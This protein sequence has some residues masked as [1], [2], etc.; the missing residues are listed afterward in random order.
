MDHFGGPKEG[1]TINS[2][3]ARRFNERNRPR[4]P[5]SQ[6]YGEAKWRSIKF[7]LCA[8]VE[9]KQVVFFFPLMYNNIHIYILVVDGEI[10]LAN[11]IFSLFFKAI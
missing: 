5:K 6:L 10:L 4:L 8:R 11:A 1:Q 7:A 3:V 9:R 2:S